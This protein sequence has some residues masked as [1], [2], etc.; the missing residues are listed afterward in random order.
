MVL[1]DGKGPGALAVDEGE[2]GDFDAGE[3]FFDEQRGSSFAKDARL[4]CVAGGPPS[5]LG[6]LADGDPFAGGQA[7]GFHHQWSGVFVDIGERGTQ[8][9]E[10]AV[11]GGGDASPR[12]HFFGERLAPLDTRGLPVGTENRA[13]F[14]AQPVGEPHGQRSFGPDDGEID[15]A[16]ADQLAEPVEVSCCDRNVLGHEGGPG[17]AGGD[18]DSVDERRLRELPGEGVLTCAGSDDENG[19]HRAIS[20]SSASALAGNAACTAGG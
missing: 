13:A 16:V 3:N 17:I 11:A 19:G 4:Q 6:G 20:I 2:E 5:F 10:E 15:D 14:G 8:V 7:V 9:I 1:G 18:E 12:H